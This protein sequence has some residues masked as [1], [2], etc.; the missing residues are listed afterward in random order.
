ME[1][2]QANKQWLNDLGKRSGG[3]YEKLL[4]T[5]TEL[6]IHNSPGKYFQREDG[7]Y[8][9]VDQVVTEQELKDHIRGQVVVGVPLS[10]TEAGGSFVKNV[11]IDVDLKKEVW[12]QEN[13]KYE[14]WAELIDEQ[15]KL[16]QEQADLFGIPY[17]TEFSGFKGKHL[18]IFFEDYIPLERAHKLLHSLFNREMI[19]EVNPEAIAWELFPKTPQIK[20]LSMVKLPYSLHRK[21]GKRAEWIDNCFPE[22]GSPVKKLSLARINELLSPT[23]APIVQCKAF[24]DMYAKV[25][26]AH[27]LSNA[28][29]VGLGT[30][31]TKIPDGHSFIIEEFFSKCDDYDPELTADKLSRMRLSDYKA[32]SCEKLMQD[33]ICQMQCKRVGDSKSPLTFFYR[34]SGN[35]DA[36]E[37]LDQKIDEGYYYIRNNKFYI[38]GIIKTKKNGETE[39]TPDEIISDFTI[40][41]KESRKLLDISDEKLNTVFVCEVRLGSKAATIN[42]KSS[43]FYEPKVLCA[44]ITNE[45]LQ[46]V[47]IYAPLSVFN[48]AM[49]HFSDIKEVYGFQSPGWQLD[50]SVYITPT[51]IIDKDG[52]RPNDKYFIR[53][54]GLQDQSVKRFD[55]IHLDDKDFNRLRAL[56]RED[57]VNMF[58]EQVGLSIISYCGYSIL[59]PLFN[60]VHEQGRFA[61][62]L[63]GITGTGKT[64]ASIHY[65]RTFGPFEKTMT[66]Q[67]TA[68]VVIG[69]GH[70]MNGAMY[71]VDDFKDQNIAHENA[72]K[73][74]QSYS[75]R[76]GRGRM[77]VDQTMRKM[78][79][80]R[81]GLFSN[82]EHGLAKEASAIARTVVI[83]T[84]LPVTVERNDRHNRLGGMREWLCGLWPRFI[85]KMINDSPEKWAKDFERN[86]LYFDKLVPNNLTGKGRII[87]NF[88]ELLT[89]AKYVID[90]LYDDKSI[91]EEKV[92][93]LRKYYKRIMIEQLT[94]TT[95]TTA[96][97]VFLEALRHGMVNGDC[98]IQKRPTTAEGAAMMK[99]NSKAVL[100]GTY[101]KNNT[102][103][104]TMDQAYH[105]VVKEMKSRGTPYTHP[106]KDL[107]RDLAN[108]GIISRKKTTVKIG[109]NQVGCYELLNNVFSD[110]G[111]VSVDD[112]DEISEKR[113]NDAI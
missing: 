6:F 60:K 82:G 3:N 1:L 65:Q 110:E 38:K 68:A 105:Y 41:I 97:T 34:Q 2:S 70:Y 106:I 44:I 92:E 36:E 53:N 91:Q 85:H 12:D 5:L 75:D 83:E 39:R 94:T 59:N 88:A 32:I 31:Y 99:Q 10:F 25:N 42:I 72:I 77:N 35:R 71:V 27:H 33:G 17:Y 51:T 56:V 101:S 50:N 112:L 86:R 15:I 103:W 84:H 62:F 9:F 96:Y 87:G 13:F 46:P 74:F 48:G 54:E 18:Y 24:R 43:D 76:Q 69:A 57:L 78:L 79:Y 61:L 104:L 52:I 21:S 26:A 19:R 16:H 28:E 14:D 37:R 20:S 47:N 66:W 11:V 90:Y 30:V 109:G 23:W 63:T 89:F 4:Q 93:M 73:V 55:M 40:V 64:T 8:S 45:M 113:K 81:G 100:V 108:V 67:S 98:V 111:A 58:E 107:I 95:D 22:D 29:R 80:I 49:M 102:I 7:G